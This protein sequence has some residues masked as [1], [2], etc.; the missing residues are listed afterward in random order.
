[1]HRPAF[2]GLLSLTSSTIVAAQTLAPW[3]ILQVESY[4]PSGRPDS[5]TI[6]YIKT[7]IT[8]P[9]S[10]SNSTATCAIEWDSLTKGES[11]YFSARECTPVEDGTWEFE[12]L[13]ANPLSSSSSSSSDEQQP[14]ISNFI[15]RLTRFTN[16]G[17]LYIGSV[18]LASGPEEEMSFMCAASGFCHAQLRPESTPLRFTPKEIGFKSSDLKTRQTDEL[19]GEEPEPPIP[20]QISH[21]ETHRPSTASATG[22]SGL[23]SISLTITEPGTG[24][25]GLDTTAKCTVEWNEAAGESPFEKVQACSEV[26]EGYFMFEVVKPEAEAEADGSAVEAVKGDE[27]PLSKFNVKFTRLAV[28]GKT[29][30]GLA[31]FEAE[32]NLASNCGSGTCDAVLKEEYIPLV[33][34]PEEVRGR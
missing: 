14:S 31:E 5:S 8:D 4:S 20:W 19:T 26:E 29:Y 17:Q 3:E 11:P 22:S 13:Q 16:D 33:V 7:T 9:N 23:S 10:A 15:L 27:M 24:F 28:G 18:S 32:K 6:S 12:V 1:M 2:L 21:V 25:D 34:V 30:L